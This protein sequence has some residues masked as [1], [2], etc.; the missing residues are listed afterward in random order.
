MRKKTNLRWGELGKLGG[1]GSN[2]SPT[3]AHI[4]TDPCSPY[5]PNKWDN[6][7]PAS[8]AA[9]RLRPRGAHGIVKRHL[10]PR[11]WFAP[12]VAALALAAT[13]LTGNAWSQLAADAQKASTSPASRREAIQAIPMDRLGPA[14]RAKVKWVL[15]NTSVYRRLPLRV[16]I[17]D[18]DLYRFLVQHPDVVVNIWQALGVSHLAMRQTDP[19]TYQVDDDAGTSGTLQFL[20]RSRDLQLIYVDGRYTG[21][22]FGHHVRGRGIMMLRSGFVRE[23]D[24]RS[25]VTSRLDAFMNIEPESAEFLSKTFQP[26]VGKVADFNFV[27][28]ADFLGSLSRTAE[29]NPSGMQRLAGRLEKVS[30]EVR[31]QFAQLAEQVAQRSLQARPGQVSAFSEIAEGE[32]ATPPEARVARRDALV[33]P[34]PLTPPSPSPRPVP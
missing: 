33:E 14:A 20:Y 13:T 12:G 21:R 1:R 23:A 27:Q 16:V 22:M 9:P 31:Q 24:G 29:I 32:A 17:C 34:S 6:R 30:P 10:G 7:L 2:R 28:A 4:L 19:D 8:Y 15:D 5:Q 11:P 3:A 26:W 18:A 25:L